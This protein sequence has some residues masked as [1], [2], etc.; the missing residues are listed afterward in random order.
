[1][2]MKKDLPPKIG[3]GPR[4]RINL[5]FGHNGGAMLVILTWA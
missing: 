2:E 1:M 4:N 5:K 3:A